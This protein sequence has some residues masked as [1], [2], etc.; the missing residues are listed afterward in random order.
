MDDEE[1]GWNA[2]VT[3]A[4]GFLRSALDGDDAIRFEMHPGQGFD[5]TVDL[6]AGYVAHKAAILA[7]QCE[8][9][10]L[11]KEL[12]LPCI[13]GI[14]E[15]AVEMAWETYAEYNPLD[16]YDHNDLSARVKHAAQCAAFMATR[17]AKAAYRAAHP[18]EDEDAYLAAQLQLA[19]GEDDEEEED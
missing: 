16:E 10:E 6:L 13:F 18:E 7:I 15:Q 19:L 11:I 3:F 9:Y 8:P 2:G 17:R 12:G 14:L 4:R 1:F 5:G